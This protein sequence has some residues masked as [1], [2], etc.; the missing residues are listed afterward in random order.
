MAPSAVHVS[1]VVSGMTHHVINS[2]LA[3][4]ECTED[5]IFQ[6]VGGLGCRLYIVACGW[7]RPTDR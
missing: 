2:L 6:K 3:P 1:K 7:V 5:Q 4:W